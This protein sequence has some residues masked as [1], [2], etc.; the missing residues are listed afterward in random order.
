MSQLRVTPEQLGAVSGR[1]G[2]VS[3]GVAD[4][5]R[6]IAGCRG[7]GSGTRAD[8]AVEELLG[9]WDAA[10]PQFALA[11]ER[12]AAAMAASGRG[13]GHTDEQVAAASSV[14]QR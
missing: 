12:L 4:L 9:R 5:Q 2:G 13:Y 14:G 11:A 3:P 1:V 8:S 10:L 7:A 6:A